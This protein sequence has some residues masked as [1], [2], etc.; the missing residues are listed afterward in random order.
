MLSTCV[1]LLFRNTGMPL[2]ALCL[3]QFIKITFDSFLLN[4]SL[5]FSAQVKNVLKF[6][7]SVVSDFHSTASYY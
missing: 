6:Y 4:D 7:I 5:L 1:K 3:F 2:L